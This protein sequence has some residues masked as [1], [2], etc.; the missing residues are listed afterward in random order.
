MTQ[1]QLPPNKLLFYRTKTL[2]PSNRMRRKKYYINSILKKF[3]PNYQSAIIHF[4]GIILLGVFGSILPISAQQGWKTIHLQEALE[5]STQNYPLIQ[6]RVSEKSSV[7]L[8]KKAAQSEY[9]P[10]L[11]LQHQYSYGSSNNLHGSFSPNEVIG[12][13]TSGTVRP[14]DNYQA[15][16]GNL[17]ALQID[18]KIFQFGK[19][20]SDIQNYQQQY[21]LAEAVYENEVFQH[22]IKVI[23]QYL[24]LLNSYKISEVQKKNVRRAEVFKESVTAFVR[25][26]IK[27][28]VD[29]FFADAEYAKALLLYI[30]A[31]QNEAMQQL[32]FSEL[33]G[34]RTQLYKVDSMHFF[35]KTPIQTPVEDTSASPLLRIYQRQISSRIAQSIAVRRNALPAVYLS[36]SGIGRGSGISRSTGVYLSDKTE[37]LTPQMYNYLLAV[38]VR[39]NITGLIRNQHLYKSGKFSVEQN[40]YLYEEQALRLNRQL[41]E[42]DVQITYCMESLKLQRTKLRASLDTYLQMKS[43]YENGIADINSFYQSL[44]LLNKAETDE[45]IALSNVWRAHLI[46]CAASGDLDS[47]LQQAN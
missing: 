38:S 8:Q 12:I 10:Q 36:G 24:Q 1:E 41:K 28:G 18:W 30:E 15:V 39:W 26:G 29:S 33:L 35:E 42:A 34:E 31:Q 20:R 23:D 27:P 46:R 3:L 37:G 16:F 19:T 14:E 47:F 9:L 44:Y 21:S 25:S 5:K 17:S 13:S 7:A 40:R 2:I 6:A 11:Q 4:F 43:R 22:Q 32:R 45:C